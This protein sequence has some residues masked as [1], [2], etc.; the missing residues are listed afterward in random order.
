MAETIFIRQSAISEFRECRRRWHYNYIRDLEPIYPDGQRP[1]R[2]AD[3][4]TLVHLGVQLYYSGEFDPA[5]VLLVMR[6]WADEEFPGWEVVTKPMADVHKG[7][8][9][10][11]KMIEGWIEDLATTG[12]DKGETTVWCEKQLEVELPG[13]WGDGGHKVVVTG[14]P[15]RLLRH[16]DFGL[17]LEDTKTTDKLDSSLIYAEQLTRYAVIIRIA[18]EGAINRLRTQQIKKVLRNGEGPFFSRPFLVMNDARYKSGWGHLYTDIRDMVRVV[19]EMDD[20]PFLITPNP[21]LNCN[22]KCAYNAPCE[23]ADDGGHSEQIVELHYRKR[24]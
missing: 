20:N 2:T 19:E 9:L 18:G 12:V 8:R 11:L 15:D 14:K 24:T 16:E 13:V 21:G 5:Q 22:W 17:I 6:G 3:I 1:F 10:A 7:V 4:G 23:S